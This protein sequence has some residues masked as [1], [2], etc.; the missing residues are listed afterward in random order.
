MSTAYEQQARGDLSAYD[1]YLR[2][3]DA[4]MKQKV[5]LTA[6][7]LLALGRVADMGMGSG[8]GSYALAALYP[9]LQVIGVD[10]NPTMVELA[11]ERHQ[12]PNLTFQAGDVAELCFPE[13]S[14][15]G[16]FDSSVLHHVTTF[17]GYDRAA[18]AR[19][20][21]T[22]ARMLTEGGM[23]IVRDFLDPGDGQVLLDLPD[24][25]GDASDEP[26]TCSTAALFLRFAREFRKLSSASGF[27]FEELPSPEIGTRRFRV[28]RA[29]AAEF[30]LRKDY[31]AD[32]E[33]E[34]LE[35][36]TYMTQHE[37]ESTYARLGLRTVAS[38]P[39]WNPWIV[40]HR[41]EGRFVMRDLE[42][43][44]FE[45]PPTNY[46]IAGEKVRAGEGVRFEERE[47]TA[48]LGFLSLDHHRHRT[49]GQVFDLVRRPHPTVD[50]VPWFDSGGQLFVLARKS[51]PRPLMRAGDVPTLDDSTP[52]QYVTEPLN[53]LQQEAPLGRTVAEALAAYA[54][55]ESGSIVRFTKGCE[56]YP[57]PGGIEERV[58][59]ALVEIE[60][61]F[62]QVDIDR[63]ASGFSTGGHV[64]AI[65]AT[66]LLRSSQVGGMSDARLEL[67]VYDLLLA[68]K[69]SAGPWIGDAIPVPN[70][71][72]LTASSL[73]S[74][75]AAPGRRAFETAA[76]GPTPFL[77]LRCARFAEFGAGGEEVASQSLEYVM[78]RTLSA[79]TVATAILARSGDDL[80]IAVDDDDLPAAQSFNGNSNLLVTPAWRLPHGLRRR[81]E[82]HR[83]IR[84][85]IASEYGLETSAPRELGGPY[86][87]SP[88]LTPERVYPLALSVERTTSLGRLHW[89]S[90][91]EAIAHADQLR[92]GH[93]R[94]VL[95]RAAHAFGLL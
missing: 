44:V 57:S 82:A 24:H 49:T 58:Q 5:A 45:F 1:R 62:V 39:L 73:P 47:A 9:S 93:L 81:S 92:D 41:Y 27:T 56:Y 13:N 52:A 51:Y 84:E 68:T 20:L 21:E 6:A 74:L 71:L 29:L 22:Q 26:R 60:P 46:V 61:S 11:R 23:L 19:A 70:D 50:I 10:V 83:W 17:S 43:N 90:I 42:G 76:A 95:F 59:S 32:W 40:H 69:R 34:V 66:Q 89:I 14:L 33:T 35:E 79:N 15:H 25:D 53:I 86:H 94:I 38:T 31:R 78:P 65:E 77:E 80:L 2:G 91:R 7:H 63:T 30:V 67:N 37:F 87:P 54:S 48:P 85:R 88:G 75:L 3:M 28:T 16:I 18:A 55:I 36:Y 8:T 4:S 72:Q 12:L 64:R